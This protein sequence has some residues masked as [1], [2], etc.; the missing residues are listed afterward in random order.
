MKYKNLRDTLLIA[1]IFIAILSILLSQ[2]YININRS[3]TTEDAVLYTTKST[4]SFTGIVVRDET[5]IYMPFSVGSGVIDYVVSDGMRLS[6]KSTIANVYDSY[7]QIYYRYRIEK[8]EADI[9]LLEQ[10]Q[11][12][13]TTDYAQPEFISNQIVESYKELL[14]R[15]SEGDYLSAYDESNDML[16]LMCIFNINTNVELDFTARIEKLNSELSVYK[17]ALKNPI[18][19]V[20]ST[21]T[22][23]FTSSL[24]GYESELTLNDIYSLTANDI[25]D[26]ISNP[27][28]VT[29]QYKNAVGK[30][31]SDYAWKMVGIIDTPDRYFVNEKLRF[32]FS[33]SN[34]VHTA[35]VESITPT[36]NGNEA[37]IIIS[38][39]E[40]DSEIASLRVQEVN[41]IFEEFSGLKVSRSAIRFLNGEKGVYVNVG[42]NIKFK[43]LDVI[44]EGD[45]YVLSKNVSDSD[46]LNLY[47]RIILEPIESQSQ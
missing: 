4:V 26:I 42:E 3:N 24:D 16:K 1:L 7:D 8:L 27:S 44:Y 28:K 17:A 18:T 6:K 47:D 45:D 23:Y 13:G 29:S 11:N 14:N 37:I 41:L 39:D 32:T 34:T 21:E 9:A 19:T 30:V 20:T 10:A 2:I 25:N 43:K 38:C 12:H 5:V 22:G 33:S 46:Y 15:V 36:G 31:F 40:L 35:L